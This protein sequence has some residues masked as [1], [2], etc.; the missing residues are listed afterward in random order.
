MAN[1]NKDERAQ[2]AVESTGGKSG[3]GQERNPAGPHAKDKLTDPEKTP[4]AGSLPD[5][6]GKEADIGPD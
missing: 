2:E 1:D 3:G 6:Q 5:D 4:G